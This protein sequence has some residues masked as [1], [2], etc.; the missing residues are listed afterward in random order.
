MPPSPQ[1]LRFRESEW[2]NFHFRSIAG[3]RR[4][5]ASVAEKLLRG[6]AKIAPRISPVIALLKF[7]RVLCFFFGR[8][9][10][11]TRERT[12]RE[13]LKTSGAGITALAASRALKRGLCLGP[14]CCTVRAQWERPA[15]ARH[16]LVK[17]FS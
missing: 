3:F 12:Q 4:S 13:F 1:W 9:G 16:L 10:S 8:G 11:M 5:V 17:R 6:N 7:L 2:L 14:A 15:G